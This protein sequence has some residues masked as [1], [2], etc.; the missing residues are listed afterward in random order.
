MTLVERDG[1]PLAALVHDPAV[2]ADPALVDA[3]AAAA[4]MAAANA[5]LQ[6]AVR[7]QV[8]EVEGSQ[9]R[10]LAAGAEERRRLE[11]RM[12]LGASGGSG[13][14]GTRSR[15]APRGRRRRSARLERAEDV[16][17]RA[18]EDLAGLAADSTPR[19]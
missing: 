1:E 3:V 18:R 11:R 10:M 8:A 7:P 12:R 15:G 13:S 2:L 17:A 9:R 4:R 14:S 5:R 6:A 16:L 19:A